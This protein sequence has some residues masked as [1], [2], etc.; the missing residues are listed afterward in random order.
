MKFEV[1]KSI[2]E[3]IVSAQV[4][5][6]VASQLGDPE[7]L[8]TGLVNAA[9]TRKVNSHGKVSQYNSENKHA[10]LE[11]LAGQVIREAARQ[12]IEKIVAEQRPLIQTAVEE[13]LRRQPKK[14][15]AAIVSAFAEGAGNRYRT[16]VH[17]TFSETE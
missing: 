14:T 1:D 8:I 11:V 15:A 17:F 5:A 13:H 4:A 7:K 6:A 3:P 9:L 2:V 16:A 12:A 10:F